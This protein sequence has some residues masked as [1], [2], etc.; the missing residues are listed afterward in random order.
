MC[1]ACHF[2]NGTGRDFGPDL[3]HLGNRASREAILESLLEPSKVIAPGFQPAVI[4]TSE[5]TLSGFIVKEDNH[6]LHLKLPTGQTQT[7]ITNRVTSRKTLP[8][9][10]MPEGQLQALTAQEA[11]DLLAYLAA[12]K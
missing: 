2:I 4:E 6:A 10:L 12:L 7:I 9:S 5:G 1:L 11:A 8:V 3:S